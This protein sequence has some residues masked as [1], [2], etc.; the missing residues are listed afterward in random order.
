[1]DGLISGGGLK[2]GGALKWDFT[3]LCHLQVERLDKIEKILI[4]HHDKPYLKYLFW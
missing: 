1:M 2:T 4:Q 3:V